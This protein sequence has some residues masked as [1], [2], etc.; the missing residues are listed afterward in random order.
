[1][2]KESK[3]AAKRTAPYRR[4]SRKKTVIIVKPTEM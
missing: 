2:R 3:R 4:C 1:V